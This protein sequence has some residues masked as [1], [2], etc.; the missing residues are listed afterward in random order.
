LAQIIAQHT[1]EYAERSA[2]RGLG[3][4]FL[5]PA[6]GDSSETFA[7]AL[8]LKLNGVSSNSSVMRGLRQRYFRELAGRTSCMWAIRSERRHPF[9]DYSTGGSIDGTIAACGATC[10][11]TDTIIIAGTVSQSATSPT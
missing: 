5:P 8:D 10:A 3:Y 11:A 7:G 9:I 1:A 4:N 6:A 2:A